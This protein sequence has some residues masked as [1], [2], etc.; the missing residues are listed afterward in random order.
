MLR[1]RLNH[2]SEG[3]PLYENKYA[4]GMSPLF[5]ARTAVSKQNI[6]EV[7]NV[8][9]IF[10]AITLYINITMVEHREYDW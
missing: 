1:L 7:S 9:I 4:L 6:H 2:V 3:V 10:I 8:K 5:M